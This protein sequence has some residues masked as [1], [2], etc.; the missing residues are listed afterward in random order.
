MGKKKKNV[1][2]C[3]ICGVKATGH[4]SESTPICDNTV[5]L[6]AT[7]EHVAEVLADEKNKNKE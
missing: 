2:C 7:I 3:N 5:C 1:A 6:E 4:F